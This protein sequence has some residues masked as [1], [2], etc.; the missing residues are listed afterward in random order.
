M[1]KVDISENITI[2]AAVGDGMAHSPGVAGKFLSALGKVG[3]NIRA[4]AQGS[5]ERNISVVVNHNDGRKALRA[6]HADFYLSPYTISIG[7][8]GTGLIG[9][10]LLKQ[11]ESQADS[12]RKNQNIDLQVRGI[13]NSK[14]MTLF[15]SDPKNPHH[16]HH[17]KHPLHFEKFL[18]HVG[19]NHIPHAVIIDCSSSS[20]L[21]LNYENWF[22]KGFHIITP[23]K[24]GLSSDLNLYNK[25]KTVSAK[26]NRHYLYS[27]NVGAGLPII[28]TI[29]D[30][31]R[32][33]TR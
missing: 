9:N 17:H 10:T 16:Q 20:E 11:F 32:L 30:M 3:V 28:R 24:K 1:E 27:T 22:K 12:L 7:V 8:L 5:S 33:G 21:P 14:E 6:V 2:L 23:N 19:A 13:S 18:D 25:I 15:E 29:R 4:I 31:R 26:C